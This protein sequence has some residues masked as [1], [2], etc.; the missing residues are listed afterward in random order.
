M[1]GVLKGLAIP[2]RRVL[3]GSPVTGVLDVSGGLGGVCAHELMSWW[4]QG[5]ALDVMH[6]RIRTTIAPRIRMMRRR[7]TSGFH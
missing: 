5:L 3:R 6:G 7:R 2:G 4:R 1:D